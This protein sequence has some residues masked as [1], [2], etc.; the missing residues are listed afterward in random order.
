MRQIKVVER[1][2][3]SLAAFLR[4]A[5]EAYLDAEAVKREHRGEELALLRKL[6]A[7]DVPHADR[8]RDERGHSSAPV[9]DAS[10]PLIPA[11]AYPVALPPAQAQWRAYPSPSYAAAPPLAPMPPPPSP[12]A[13]YGHCP[14]AAHFAYAYPSQ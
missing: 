7:R 6:V 8:P 10:T 1:E 3:R 13:A 4:A 2:V 5:H 9:I 11:G 14:A 12:M